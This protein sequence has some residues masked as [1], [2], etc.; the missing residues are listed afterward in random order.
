MKVLNESLKKR[1]MSELREAFNQH[2]RKREKMRVCER[3]QER[4]RE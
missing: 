3:K 4:E 1:F 2:E